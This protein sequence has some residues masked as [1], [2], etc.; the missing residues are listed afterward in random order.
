MS[1]HHYSVVVTTVVGWKYLN[2]Q[3]PYK[4]CDSILRITTDFCLKHNLMYSYI[5]VS[6]KIFFIQ[7]QYYTK[8]EHVICS[9]LRQFYIYIYM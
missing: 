7:I 4:L 9:K 8:I 6:L 2:F 1:D 3:N 5:L